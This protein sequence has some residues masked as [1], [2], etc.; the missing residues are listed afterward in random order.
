MR[1]IFL[2]K[3]ILFIFSILFILSG[4]SINNEENEKTIQDKVNEEI[5]FLEN[6]T[7]TITNKYAKGEYLVDEKLNWKD[8][9][10]EVEEIN[11]SIDTIIQDLSELDISNEDILA[12]RNEVNSLLISSGNE[13]EYNLL[14]RTSYLYSLLPNYLEKYSDDKNQVDVMKLK[15]LI[16]SSFVQA[17]F[18][19]WDTAKNTIVLAEAKYNEMMNNVDY[20]KE[21]SNN[22]NKI[23]VL[24]EEL[25]NAIELQEVELTKVKFVN[26]IEKY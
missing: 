18:L 24:L 4:C 6:K 5:N 1:K 13:D 23:Y 21:Y 25:K 22:L 7:F 26:F 8:I 10:K 3:Y 16:L 2:I 9:S 19:E 12:L 14:Q 17:N 15:S 11:L 20:M